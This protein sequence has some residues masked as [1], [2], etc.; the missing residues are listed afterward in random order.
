MLS[1]DRQE[2]PLAAPRIGW[3]PAAV[4]ARDPRRT[5]SGEAFGDGGLVRPV[6]DG[7]EQHRQRSE[8]R[9]APGLARATAWT[10][11]AASAPAAK[12]AIRV[13]V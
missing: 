3:R 4:Q 7:G 9:G 10:V 12:A 6:G 13:S 5:G 8:G 2:L 11:A 1:A